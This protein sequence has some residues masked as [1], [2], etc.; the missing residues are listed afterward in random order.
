MAARSIRWPPASCR[1]RWARRPRPSVRGGRPQGLPLHHRLGR[2]ARDRRREG[3]VIARLSDAR[4]VRRGDRRGRCR[5]S[6]ARS[7]RCPPAYSAIK[8]DGERAYDLARAGETVELAPRRGA[9]RPAVALIA[10]VDADHAEFEVE[11]GKGTY[12]RSP[13]PRHRPRRWAPWAMSRPAPDRR[14]GHFASRTR[15]R[16]LRWNAAA[17]NPGGFGH[18]PAL[19]GHLLPVETALDDIP[20]LALTDRQARR[21]SG[22]WPCRWSCLPAPSADDRDDVARQ[23]SAEPARIV[24]AMAGRGWWR[25]PVSTA[26]ARPVRVLNL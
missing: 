20:A 8:V 21:L 6:S 23:G 7:S 19:L 16:W 12:V 26:T 13:G 5:A 15:Y 14:S 18:K 24:W 22:E 10:T 1:S 2:G 9:D 4:P 3:E 11:C 17:N 25:S